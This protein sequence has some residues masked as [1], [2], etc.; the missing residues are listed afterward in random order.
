MRKTAT[1]SEPA[2][3]AVAAIKINKISKSISS[4]K[5]V[6]N[7]K[8]KKDESLTTKKVIGNS[9]IAKPSTKSPLQVQPIIQV[10]P[11]AK[12]EIVEFESKLARSNT[13]CI[14]ENTSELLGLH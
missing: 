14:D 5:V 4:N 13:F 8:I 11:I 3:V 1:L 12:E 9:K 7:S 2:S 6:G 10:A